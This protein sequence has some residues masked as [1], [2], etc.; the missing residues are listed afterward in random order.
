M[1]SWQWIRIPGPCAACKEV[2]GQ[3]S[4]ELQHL[5]VEKRREELGL[6]AEADCENGKTMRKVRRE[7]RKSQQHQ[8]AR[9]G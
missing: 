2:L 3:S 8:Q 9:A 1:K 4:K 7:A 6:E 5:M